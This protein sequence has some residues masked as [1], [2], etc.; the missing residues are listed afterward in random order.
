MT[1]SMHSALYSATEDKILQ[2]RTRQAVPR[3]GNIC[4]EENVIENT[5]LVMVVTL[6]QHARTQF[7]FP[8]GLSSSHTAALSM[9]TL[10]HARD[11]AT[12]LG[13]CFC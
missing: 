10:S 8:L 5:R 9:F 1:Q 6:A 3:A 11:G 13:A 12:T 7:H 4:L 2:T